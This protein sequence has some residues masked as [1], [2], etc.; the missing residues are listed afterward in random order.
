MKHANKHLLA[1]TLV[2]AA[3][4]AHAGDTFINGQI[5]TAKFNDTDYDDTRAG[6]GQ[7]S[8]G[9]RWGVGPAHIGFEV[10]GGSTDDLKDDYHTE[11]SDGWQDQH[12]RMS[13]SY[14]F[15]GANARVD[16]P[17]TPVYFIGRLGYMGYD[18]RE[19][20][21]QVD[22]YSADGST[23]HS[24]AHS[25]DDGGGVYYGVGVGFTVL[26]TL[27]LSLNYTG[28]SYSSRYYDDY[29]DE[30]YWGDTKTAHTTTVGVE[31]RF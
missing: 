8:I 13:T 1:L 15:V 14:G 9:H 20:Y 21:T 28:M 19:K 26:P 25:H 17:L 18:Q 23:V 31:W 30:Y 27:S 3:P 4:L 12:Y 5:G 7:I 2:A 24:H 6:V 22:Y 29:D 16:L 10:G 11:L